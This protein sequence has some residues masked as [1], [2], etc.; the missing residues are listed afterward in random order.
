MIDSYLYVTSHSVHVKCI[1]SC[2]DN[3][4]AQHSNN[5]P[6]LSSMCCMSGFFPVCQHLLRSA[7]NIRDTAAGRGPAV[8]GL[9]LPAHHQL[10][11]VSCDSDHVESDHVA[12]QSSAVD[13]DELLP[14][15]ADR[16]DQSVVAVDQSSLA[17]ALDHQSAADGAQLPVADQF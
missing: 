7:T 4:V 15:G 3:A 12:G 6:T 1:D 2:K 16:A 13:Q 8:T 9:S 14:E 5:P 10:H 11:L 17:L